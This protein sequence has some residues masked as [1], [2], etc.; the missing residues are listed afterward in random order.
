MN[1][2]LLLQPVTQFDSFTVDDRPG[3]QWIS[4]NRKFGEKEDIKIEATMFDGALRNPKSGGAGAG[5][6]EVNL[7]IT[8]IV[9]ISKEGSDDVLE[10]VCSAWPDFLEIEKLSIRKRGNMLAKPYDGPEYKYD[11]LFMLLLYCCV[12]V[13]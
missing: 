13:A 12:S 2:F 8:L 7:H 11:S 3:E 10:F 6:Q 4:L 9:N 1:C 5:E